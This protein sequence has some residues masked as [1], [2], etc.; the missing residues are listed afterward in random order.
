[1]DAAVRLSRYYEANY[2]EYLLNVFAIN[3]N[4]C[5]LK[6][7]PIQLRL[8]IFSRIQSKKQIIEKLIFGRQF[9]CVVT[10]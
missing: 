7:F 4:M 2:P 8:R 9:I 3:G 10:L 1:M 6:I 5:I